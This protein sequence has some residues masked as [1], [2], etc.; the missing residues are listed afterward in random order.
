M[1][2]PVS[3]VNL[4]KAGGLFAIW[5][6]YGTLSAWQTHYWYS[7]TKT[8]MS[9]AESL[10]F[11]VS[12]AWLWAV[13]TPLILWLARRFRIERNHWARHL[14]IHV[15]VMTLLI[16]IVKTVFDAVTMP[17]TSAFHDFTWARWLRSIE[18]TFDTGTLLYWIIILVEHSLVYYRR[19]QQGLVNASHLQTQLVQAQLRALKMQLH[20]HFLFNT[21]HTITA[22]VHEDPDLAERTIAR[23]S[24]L[25]RLFLAN[26][27]VHEVP[28]REE[29]R[30]LD[31]YL[32]IERTRFE[33][34]LSVHF[35]VPPEL[36]DAMVPNLVLQPLVEN[37]IRHGVGRRSAPGWI[38]VS[39]EKYGE[40]LVL[41][42]ADNGG[43]L[44]H[45]AGGA[46]HPVQTGMG[47]AITRGRLESLYG[48]HQ[49]LVL[50]DVA[51]GGA[52][53]RI[54]M[55][56]RSHVEVS[57]NGENAALQSINR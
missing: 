5:T 28:L 26:S 21:L 41:R 43:G 6:S 2:P 46:K 11:E 13:C 3:R 15:G 57:E 49:S 29:L 53:A 8:P 45:G 10:R 7:F 16:A 23:L 30:I 55:P 42:V 24:E 56:F 12:Y 27:T 39:A 34:R 50:R 48:E 17:P 52:E 35:D 37:A 1:R 25:L 40:T 32:E 18:Y 33:D 14:A 51:T 20:P 44:Q 4:I 47:L 31:L 9:W 38:S 22:L 36:R 54:T 19:Y